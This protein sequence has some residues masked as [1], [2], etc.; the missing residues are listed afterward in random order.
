MHIAKE[1]VASDPCD[2]VALFLDIPGGGRAGRRSDYPSEATRGELHKGL[3]YLACEDPCCVPIYN[4]HV[5]ESVHI[6]RRWS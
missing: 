1:G 4:M 3:Y 6:L 5:L 2:G